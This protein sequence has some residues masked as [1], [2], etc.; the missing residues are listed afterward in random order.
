MHDTEQDDL[1]NLCVTR[2]KENKKQTLSQKKYPSFNHQTDL[3]ELD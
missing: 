2:E 1:G 3:T